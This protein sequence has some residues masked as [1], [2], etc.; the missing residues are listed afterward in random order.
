MRDFTVGR[1]IHVNGNMNITDQSNNF[2]LFEFC[3]N[4]EL[5]N[6]EVHRKALLKNERSD[7]STKL[8]KMMAFAALL[9]FVAAVWY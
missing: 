4:D 2:K 1:D 6:E 3:S 5:F 8:L 7:R 9:L